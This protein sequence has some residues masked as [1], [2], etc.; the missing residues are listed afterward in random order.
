MKQRIELHTESHFSENFSLV[1]PITLIE[2]LASGGCSA[3]AVT[4]RH[5]V[6]SYYPATKA[7]Q[8]ANIR[9]IYGVTL[10]CI[11]EDD[12]YE[13]TV[14]ARTRAGLDNLFR[15]V[16]LMHRQGEMV[17]KHITRGQLEELR[18]GL[19]VGACAQN[20]QLARAI[21]LHKDENTLRRITQGYDYL[22]VSAEPYD[23]CVETCRLAAEMG[24]P[25]CA[26]QDTRAIGPKYGPRWHAYR[27][28]RHYWGQPDT[29]PVTRDGA[30]LEE[31][32]RTLYVLPHEADIPQRVL[33]D[34]PQQ[35]LEQIEEFSIL[36]E[37]LAQ[38]AEEEHRE[39]MPRLCIMAEDK[40]REKYGVHIPD[41]CRDQLTWE[42]QQ[43]DS[44]LGAK[45][46][47]YLI[48][49]SD[50]IHREQ[51]EMMLMGAWG[52]SYF[53]YLMGV[54]EFN[55]LP[56]HVWCPKCGH[57]E[58]TTESSTCCPACGEVL[59][60]EGY[61][62]AAGSCFTGKEGSLCR[63]DIRCSQNILQALAKQDND[64][65]WGS[66]AIP[67]TIE[68]H[69]WEE[70]STQRQRVM[71]AYA[72]AYGEQDNTMNM[73]ED[74]DF[75]GLIRFYEEQK[76][77]RDDNMIYTILPQKNAFPVLPIK[78]EDVGAADFGRFWDYTHD[79]KGVIEFMILHADS[80]EALYRCRKETGVIW[81]ADMDDP[82][83]YELLRQALKKETMNGD[84]Q[85]FAD[86]IH[87]Q[88]SYSYC[89]DK[90]MDRFPLTN[91]Q[92]FV[93]LLGVHYAMNATEQLDAGVAPEHVFLTREEVFRYLVA[94][95]V[96]RE[97]ATH[98]MYDVRI[99]RISRRGFTEEDTK[100]LEAHQVEPWFME[101]CRRT[102]YL[103]PEAHILSIAATYV[104]LAAYMLYENDTA[105]T[106]F[107]DVCDGWNTGK[108][109]RLWR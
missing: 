92:Q 72:A 52:S 2:T 51:G 43:I 69:I 102:Q 77:T 29:P 4:D 15:L 70:N 40:L 105:W 60:E 20:G 3:V 83:V 87:M 37:E 109:L 84:Y 41:Y 12:R 21:S 93:R 106:I 61:D 23:I 27:A 56:R 89:L 91:L 22:E 66:R 98:I 13:V 73:L 33:W 6:A 11:D 78:Y 97:D 50:F 42:L 28:F 58:L 5:S 80:Y 95:D 59:R 32:Y 103:F 53:L 64:S 34:G 88:Y 82:R 36:P 108:E 10:D 68:G 57:F 47:E 44:A 9:L 14:L 35:I 76:W 49:L 65:P 96:D 86:M 90:Y 54:T 71:D 75:R 39:A 100:L 107:Y 24:I 31:L 62:L 74:E 45:S 104:R 101:S 19:L 99:G 18:E 46:M 17:G 55:P 63:I 8:A 25:A 26:V 94:R 48:R 16:T 67:V 1:D 30:E 7:A 85:L 38:N 79:E 81:D